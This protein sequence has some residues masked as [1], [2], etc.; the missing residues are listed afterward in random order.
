MKKKVRLI[1]LGTVAV[2]VLSACNYNMINT[3]DVIPVTVS[4]AGN[5]SQTKN[6]DL[7]ALFTDRDLD[8]NVDLSKAETIEVKSNED[9]CIT[10]EGTYIITGNA[11]DCSVIVDAADA[12][13]QLVLDSLNV[14]NDSYPCIDVRAADKVFVT[15]SGD[16]SLKVIGKF[17]EDDNK[18]DAVIFS[19]DDLVLNGNATL[20]LESTDNAISGKDDLKITGGSYIISCKHIAVEANDS[21]SISDGD[22]T[23]TECNDGLHAENGKDDTVGN[24][25]IIGGTLNIKAEDDAI[26]ATTF[27]N[28]FGGDIT[29]DAAEG[30]ETAQLVIDGGKITINA[31]DDGI[32]ASRKSD[33]FKPYVIINGGEITITAG[34]GDTDGIDSNGD[35]VINGGTIDITAESPFDFEGVC[36][37]NGG[38]LTVNGVETDS[39]TSGN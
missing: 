16:S 27:L 10:K 3:P 6:P 22:I 4:P 11:S 17:T 30:I 9:V 29:L 28:I 38:I 18:S 26:H 36:E 7:S 23:V 32:N 20:T 1:A 31:S 25:T 2:A 14:T 39:I 13:I 34:A 24:I 8:Q 15:T 19:K 12:K 37:H 5:P 33:S 35:L 21:I